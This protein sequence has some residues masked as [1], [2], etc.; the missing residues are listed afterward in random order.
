VIS[1]VPLPPVTVV[2]LIVQV[3]VPSDDGTLQVRATSEPNPPTGAT[4]RLS[5]IV[6]P[7]EIDTTGLAI[8]RV[9]SAA[10]ALTVTGIGTVCVI[11][12]LVA[13]MVIEPVAADDEAFTVSVLMTA[14][15]PVVTGFGLKEHVNPVVPLQEKLTL[16]ENPRTV[17]IVM[18]SVVVLPAVTV[19]PGFPDETWKSGTANATLITTES[20]LLPLFP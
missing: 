19:S 11:E 7:L 20:L 6:P 4:V 5:V 8:V 15:A 9:K 17:A 12:P 14:D 18:E 2:G 13:V 16:P 3:V 1:A 10:P